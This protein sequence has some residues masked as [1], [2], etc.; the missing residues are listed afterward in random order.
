MNGVPL[1]VLHHQYM[2]S[3]LAK[4]RLTYE[5]FAYSYTKWINEKLNER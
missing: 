4:Y 3:P 2:S 1:E 5:Q